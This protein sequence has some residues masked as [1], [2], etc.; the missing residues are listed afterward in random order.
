MDWSHGFQISINLPKK[1]KW[2]LGSLSCKHTSYK[3]KISIGTISISAKISFT[4]NLNTPY[5]QKTK[6][7]KKLRRAFA[8]VR[9]LVEW[10]VAGATS[11]RRRRLGRPLGTSIAE[12]RPS[13]PRGI[14]SRYRVY[15]AGGEAASTK[16]NN[17][18]MQRRTLM[19]GNCC[20]NCPLLKQEQVY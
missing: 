15:G 8:D 14:V 20:R 10:L 18:R 11:I 9:L 3:W 12:R 5:E 4:L 2:S 13:V 19:V 17:R 16:T 6:S 1:I 7:D